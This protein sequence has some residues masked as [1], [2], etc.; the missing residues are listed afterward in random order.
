[1]DKK[2]AKFFRLYTSIQNRLHSIILVIVHN[3]SA[4]D[5]LLQETAATLWEKFDQFEEGTNFAA[6]AIRIAKNKCFEYLRRNE[7]TKKLFRNEFYKQA[8][9]LAVE[10]SEELSTRLKAL[11]ICCEKLDTRRRSLLKLHFSDNIPVKELSVQFGQ[12]VSTLYNHIAQALDW[13]RFC[14]KKTLSA[15]PMRSF[16]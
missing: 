2:S 7:K 16:E 5:D 10:T 1:M 11:D 13:L 4:A 14:I 9:D 6:W 12:P 8:A 3:P 15:Q